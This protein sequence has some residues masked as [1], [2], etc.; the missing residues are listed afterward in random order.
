MAGQKFTVAAYIFHF[1]TSYSELILRHCSIV[2]LV[3]GL[4]LFEKN[5]VDG[6]TDGE[7]NDILNKLN[8]VHENQIMVQ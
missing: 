7:K 3:I 2:N 8:T 5:L 6:Q 1:L 4:R